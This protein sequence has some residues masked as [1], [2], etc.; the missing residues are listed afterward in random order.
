MYE[1]IIAAL[2]QGQEISI[3]S[4]SP[5]DFLESDLNLDSISDEELSLTIDNLLDD[6]NDDFSKKLFSALDTAREIIEIN[7]E[8]FNN[9]EI[10]DQPTPNI[11]SHQ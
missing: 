7:K 4:I 5:E 9:H 8:T 6:L 1:E 3:L 2:R 10:D 11:D